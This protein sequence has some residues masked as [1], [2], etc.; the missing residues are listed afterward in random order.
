MYIPRFFY[1]GELTVDTTITLS[2]LASHHLLN[3]LRVKDEQPLIIFNGNGKEFLARYLDSHKKLARVVITAV[4]T[5]HSESPFFIEL[6]Q[7]ISRSEKMDYAI[8]KAVE[9]G[10]SRIVPLFTERC[11]VKFKS[12]RKENRLAHWQ[13]IITHACEQSGRCQ[14][15]EIAAPLSLTQWLAIKRDGL[16]LVCD[17]NAK[18]SLNDLQKPAR[19]TLLIGPESGLSDAEIKLAKEYNFVGLSLGPRILRTET[20]TV[21]ALSLIQNIFGD[22]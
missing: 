2:P 17:P 1:T 10:V 13:G 3:V 21:V 20:A 11:A 22:L 7:A 15:P 19:A 12:D 8:Q 18:Q 14:I 5:C 9:L 4:Q 16:S 6:G